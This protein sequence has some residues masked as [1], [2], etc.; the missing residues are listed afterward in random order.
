MA[1]VELKDRRFKKLRDTLEN[2][3]AQEKALSD[4]ASICDRLMEIYK[5]PNLDVAKKGEL[6]M[7]VMSS[8][9]VGV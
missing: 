8:I 3:L 2:Q 7:Q 4:K 9:Q 5:N 6:F 1:E